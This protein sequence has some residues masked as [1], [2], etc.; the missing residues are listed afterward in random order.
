MAGGVFKSDVR[1]WKQT[2]ANGFGIKVKGFDPLYASALH[3][4]VDDLNDGDDKEQRHSPQVPKSKYTNLYLD[5]EHTGVG[6]INSWNGDARA[7]PQYRVNFG[8][9]SGA[10]TIEPLL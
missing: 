2:T 9:K 5:F 6:G 4:T 3:Y 1:W 10:L 7:L 8:T